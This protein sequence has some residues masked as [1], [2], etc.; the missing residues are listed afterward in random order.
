[1]G[2]AAPPDAPDI[3]PDAFDLIVIG[4]G[5]QES[6]LAG[7]AIDR[8]TRHIRFSFVPLWYAVCRAKLLQAHASRSC[9]EG[10]AQRSHLCISHSDG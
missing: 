10:T 8:F 4:T 6:L 9:A 3:E 1:M 7:C 5:Y 2:E